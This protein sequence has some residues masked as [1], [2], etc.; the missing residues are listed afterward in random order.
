VVAYDKARQEWW[1]S[2]PVGSM[3]GHAG[4]SAVT[5][6]GYLTRSSLLPG[7]VRLSW[8]GSSPVMTLEQDS[9][10]DSHPEDQK[11]H[12]HVW[13]VTLD[14]G[15]RYWDRTSDLFGVNNAFCRL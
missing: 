4:G 15:G 10:S 9:H 1:P 11:G 2:T 13:E 12:S 7:T 14:L 8:I 3:I 6:M 5:E